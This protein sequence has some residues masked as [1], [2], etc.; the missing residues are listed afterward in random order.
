[1]RHLGYLR[2]TVAGVASEQWRA[3]V[4]RRF[5]KSTADSSWWHARQPIASVDANLTNGSVAQ[6][7]GYNWTG[8]YQSDQ[9]ATSQIAAVA[10]FASLLDDQ[11]P[12]PPN[13]RTSVSPFEP[14]HDQSG[15]IFVPDGSRPTDLD[16]DY[17]TVSLT[18]VLGLM[19]MLVVAFYKL[20][21]LHP[22]YT[23]RYRISEDRVLRG[24]LRPIIGS[25]SA[26]AAGSTRPAYGATAYVIV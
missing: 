16:E 14:T 6:L 5:A 24:E 13:Q 11:P 7:F 21:S 19:A 1:M 10:L 4:Y 23:R 18:M 2:R 8:P 22:E 3:E 15:V 25:D 17:L 20:L 9:L 12:P 26:A